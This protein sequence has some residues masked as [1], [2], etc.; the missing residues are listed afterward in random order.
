MTYFKL[1]RNLSELKS[2]VT[3]IAVRTNQQFH[4]LISE[5]SLHILENLG[6]RSSP[7]P[8]NMEIVSQGSYLRPWPDLREGGWG[9]FQIMPSY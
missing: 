7:D 9:W 8:T 2:R 4:S 3:L 5:G 1:A 6:Q